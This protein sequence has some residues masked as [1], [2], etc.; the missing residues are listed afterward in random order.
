MKVT[1]FFIL[2]F[3]TH[4]CFAQTDTTKIVF[5]KDNYKIQYPKSWQLDTSKI[6]GTNF[7][8]LAPLENATDKFRENVNGIIQDL[9][10]QNIDLEKYKQITDKQISEFVTDSKVFESAI[11][12][13]NES[14]H[15]YKIVYAITQGK[16]RLKITSF[17]FIKNDK[18]YLVTF[19]TEFDK[20]EQYKNVGEEILNS[21]LLIK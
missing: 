18:A 19:T 17:C 10:G 13:S 4:F 3:S 20:Y 9:R 12:K 15:Y 5:A 11:I 21:F 1:F 6:M 7:F 16:F 14:N 8:V 2:L